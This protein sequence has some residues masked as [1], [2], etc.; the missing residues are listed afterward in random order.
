M[1]GIRG[2]GGMGED[3]AA[4]FLINKGFSVLARNWRH[5]RLEIDLV[6]MDG[7]AIVFVE[8]KTR[9]NDN[10]GGGSWAVSP[11][12]IRNLS[13]AADAWLASEG[14]WA[15]PCRFDVVCL[16][17]CPASFNIQHYVN[18]FPYVPSVDSFNPDW[19]Y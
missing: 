4:A 11:R 7:G 19:Q 1:S 9:R 6:C 2:L 14:A 12:K 10:R 5:G 17:G 15:S 8:V 16:T 18:A 13:R 3:A